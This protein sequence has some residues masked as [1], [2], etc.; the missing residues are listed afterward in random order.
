[1][2]VGVIIHSHTGNTLS[3]GEKLK[4]TIS[5]KGHIVHLQ[6]VR[7]MNEDPAAAGKIELSEIPDISGYD[8]VIFA[9]PV[10]AFSLSPV[11]KTYLSQLPDLSNKK[12]FC[13]VT[14]QLPRPW[15]G[16][17]RAIKQMIQLITEKGGKVSD[18][19]IVNWSC[20]D[21]EAQITDI[22]QRFS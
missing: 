10:R 21:R 11:M 19:S 17:N 15:M 22:L 9:A 20:K 7:A 4:E 18:Q 14:Q 2:N 12:I 5:N 1:M 3:V 16:G 6:R 13:F 8:T